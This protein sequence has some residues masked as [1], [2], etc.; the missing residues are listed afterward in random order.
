MYD[1]KTK[2]TKYILLKRGTGISL[3]YD[4]SIDNK[5]KIWYLSS[6]SKDV[7]LTRLKY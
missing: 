6:R 5:K 3:E 2:N 4:L 7:W 1:I